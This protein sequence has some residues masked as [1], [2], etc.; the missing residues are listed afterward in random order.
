MFGARANEVLALAIEFF[1]AAEKFT[2]GQT[3]LEDTMNYDIRAVQKR[4]KELGFN[5]GPI[6]GVLGR[7]TIEAVKAF[8]VKEKLVSCF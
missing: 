7:R 6:D 4:L 1:Q 3:R 8:Q 2:N 5:P